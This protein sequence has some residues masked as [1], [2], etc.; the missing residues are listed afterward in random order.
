M[1]TSI[2]F[3]HAIP[4][5]P[6]LDLLKAIAFYEQHLGFTRKFVYD[7][8]VGISRGS[9]EL[10]LWLCNDPQI[11]ENTSCRINVK[12]ID[13]LY[14]EYWR[15]NVIHPNGELVVKPWG[16]KE[17]VILDLNGNAIHFAETV[18]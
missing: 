10:H 18:L 15:A 3:C 9:V 8:Y 12:N 11:P 6:A 14:E 4:V 7:D 5:M 17:F 16:L 1:L 2:E 13:E